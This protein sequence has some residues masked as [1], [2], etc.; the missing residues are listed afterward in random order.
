MSII[1]QVEEGRLLQSELSKQ[2]P[3]VAVE[4]QKESILNSRNFKPKLNLKNSVGLVCER[5][6]PIKRPPLV[7]EVIA[8]CCR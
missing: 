1:K 5:T 8:N 4:T 6:I 7:G 3:L 2:I